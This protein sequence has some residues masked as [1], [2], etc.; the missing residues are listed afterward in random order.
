MNGQSFGPKAESGISRPI[1]EDQIHKAVAEVFQLHGAKVRESF[2]KGARD[3]A[4]DGFSGSR[5]PSPSESVAAKFRW[6]RSKP[7]SCLRSPPARSTMS[8]ID[9]IL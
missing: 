7:V 2:R 6:V 4:R 5:I 9:L 8:G 1:L 3:Q